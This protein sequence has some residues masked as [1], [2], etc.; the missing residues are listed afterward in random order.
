VRFIDENGEASGAPLQGQVVV[1]IGGK[2][3]AF[4]AEFSQF[5]VVLHVP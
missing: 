1:Y 4:T 5:G 2:V 3:Q